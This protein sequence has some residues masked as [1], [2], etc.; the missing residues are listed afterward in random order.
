M[1]VSSTRTVF[2]AFLLAILAAKESQAWVQQNVLSRN[3]FKIGPTRVSP[4]VLRSSVDSVS[5]TGFENHEEEGTKMA[6]SIAAWLDS[7]WMPQE[8]H[9]RMGESA[10]KSYIKCREAGD[11]DLMNIM[12]TVADDLTSKWFEEY[13]ADA[14]VGAWDI[15]NYVSDYLVQVSGQEGCECSN[16][17]Y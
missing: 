6:K 4:V 8:V 10:K 14:F 7:E 12:S 5:L 9:V 17:V 3:S 11:D 16:K 15:A 13:D 1:T 2:F